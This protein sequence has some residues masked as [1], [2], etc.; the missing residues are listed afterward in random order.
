MML[1]PKGLLPPFLQ[2]RAHNDIFFLILKPVMS[3]SKGFDLGT[4]FC[5]YY[6]RFLPGISWV[7]V[8]ECRLCLPV[9]K[10]SDNVQAK[11]VFNADES[12]INNLG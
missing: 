11:P 10:T 4:S 1:R 2:L 3:Q 5:N 8:M 6:G 12:Y 7:W 9:C